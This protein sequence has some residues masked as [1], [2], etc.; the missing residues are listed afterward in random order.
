MSPKSL[1]DQPIPLEE[2]GRYP[3]PGMALPQ[4]LAFSQD[5]RLVTYLFSP[6]K[7]LVNSLYARDLETGKT[8]RLA[9]TLHGSQNEGDIS[10]EEAL[11]R[12]RQRQRNLGITSYAWAPQGTRMLIPQQ[13]SLFALDD[14]FSAPRLLVEAGG[15]PVLDPHFSPDAEQVAFV[16]DAELCVVPFAGGQ[17]LD[18]TSGALKKGWTHALAGYIAQ[19]EM[20]RFNGYWWSTDS[21]W[22]AYEEVD[23]THIPEYPILHLGKDLTGES[24]AEVHRYPFAGAENAHVRLGVVSASGGETVWMDLDYAE[25]VY[26]ARVG[27]LPDGR[28]SAQLENRPQTWLELVVFDPMTG[29]RQL[30]LREESQAWI[31]LHNLFRPLKDGRFIWASERSGFRHLELRAASGAL[32]HTLTHGAWQ[33]DAIAG[34]DQ[35]GGTVYFTASKESPLESHL[36]AVPLAGGHIRRITTQ[37]GM[38]NVV[39]DSQFTCF[40]DTSNH[41]EQPP[42][43]LVCSLEDGTPQHTLFIDRDARIDSLGLKPPQPLSFTNRHGD[44]LY[45]AI[46]LPPPSVAQPPYPLIVSL[47]GG[48]HVQMVTQGWAMSVAMRAQA[49]ARLGLAVFVMDNRGSARRGLVFEAAIKG[50]LGHSEVE[51][52]V[53]G[54]RW[55]VAQGLAD[56]QRVG[57]YGWSYGG[58]MALMC[59]ARAPETFKAALA[60]AP[61]THWDGY[62][63]CYTER[64]M[65]TP[66][67]NPQGYQVSSVMQH[68]NNITGKLLIMHGLIDENVHFRH[69]ARLIN[70]LI[71]AGVNYDLLLFPDERHMPRSLEGRVYMEQRVQQFFIN[72]LK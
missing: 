19:E 36:Y 55:L 24:A 12:E 5:G 10:R 21:R 4:S 13:D 47:Y 54:V 15:S 52:Q 48:P 2:V 49:F 62:D 27:W 7:S 11:R 31:N 17:P 25:E 57:V 18:L 38:H 32:L 71:R 40:I 42:Q 30:L 60:G 43:V 14:P 45:G 44:R 33:V 37:P 16:R 51:D 41:L 28:L 23:E 29:Q 63:T 3:L 68:V 46:Y 1:S 34:V 9:E 66:Q 64:Y 70:A 69:T 6:E 8:H 50:D 65:G 22:L 61:V 59:L 39:L 56:P 58:Y 35:T 20:D 53:D 67:A 26:L 72:N